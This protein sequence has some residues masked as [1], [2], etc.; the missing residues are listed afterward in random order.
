MTAG[1]LYDLDDEVVAHMHREF[2]DPEGFVENS[3]I[4]DLVL[5]LF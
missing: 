2:S 5:D 4:V 1:E 3:V